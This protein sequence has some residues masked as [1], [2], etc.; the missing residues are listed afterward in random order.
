MADETP[1]E[2][3]SDDVTNTNETNND[4]NN[5]SNGVQPTNDAQAST[6]SNVETPTTSGTPTTQTKATEAPQK[7]A[8]K[9]THRKRDFEMGKCLGEGSY[10]K[11]F[12]AK[13]INEDSPCFGKKYA[14]KIMD[15][16]HIVKHDKI[17]YVTIEKKV[18]LKTKEHPF[19]CH[20]NFSFQDNYSLFMVLDLC[21]NTE[22]SEIIYKYVKL[23]EELTV[24]YISELI[25]ALKYM[26]LKG[27]YH[28]DLKPENILIHNDGHIRLT[29]FGTAKIIDLNRNDI[30]LLDSNTFADNNNTNDNS[31]T[32]TNN[33]SHKM[34]RKESFLGT[35]AYVPPELLDQKQSY[36]PPGYVLF[37]NVFVLYIV[38][39][40]QY[41]F[42]NIE[43]TSGH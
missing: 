40:S 39:Y 11:V 30:D 5:V 21:E 36:S 34:Q 4:G 10:A 31:E 35:A 7:K 12:E 42:F 19:I 9:F 24:F 17:K 26:H 27:I 3:P 8:V 41:R 6:Q 25:S 1:T 33:G 18:F 38:I 22:L 14:I 37:L 28:R 43:W 15:K 23:N 32:T 16:K 20:L 2:T 13:V 29:D